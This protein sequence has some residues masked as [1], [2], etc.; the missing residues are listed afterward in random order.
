MEILCQ[1]H[2]TPRTHTYIEGRVPRDSQTLYPVA[3]PIF[4]I[5]ISIIIAHRK[6]ALARVLS[7]EIYD[8]SMLGKMETENPMRRKSI[9]SSGASLNFAVTNCTK[10][11]IFTKL[12]SVFDFN[13]L[14]ILT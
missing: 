8:V 13:F 1:E 6:R 7:H 5:C 10:Y 2:A 4:S 9:V 3:R 14:I 11:I 12:N